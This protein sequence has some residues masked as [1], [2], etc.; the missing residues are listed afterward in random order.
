[1]TTGLIIETE[2]YY[3][4]EDKACHA[5]ANKKTKRNAPMFA[6]GGIAYVYLCYGLHCLLNVVTHSEGE[7]HAVLIRAIEP[8][9][10]IEEMLARRSKS[11]LDKTLSAGPGTLTRSLGVN[12]ADSGCDLTSGARLW[13]EDAPVIPAERIWAGPRIGIA[14]YAQ[15]DT[16][17]PWRFRV[18]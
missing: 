9:A 7:P 13:I 3:G 2:A 18:L 6:A 12:L 14:N 8:V 10:G 15:E 16:D 4:A 1:M 11:K 5:H 17:K